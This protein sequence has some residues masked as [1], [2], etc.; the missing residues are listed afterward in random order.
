M[1]LSLWS[2]LRAQPDTLRSVEQPEELQA[3]ALPDKAPQLTAPRPGVGALER[4]VPF[5]TI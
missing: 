3:F 5:L 2:P 1:R 4:S